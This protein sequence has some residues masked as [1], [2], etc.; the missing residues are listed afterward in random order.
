MLIPRH[1]NHI[2]RIPTQRRSEN[3]EMRF[4]NAEH[5]LIYSEL[6]ADFPLSNKK[7]ASKS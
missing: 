3:G 7:L 5:E 6:V 2:T 4:F 1:G